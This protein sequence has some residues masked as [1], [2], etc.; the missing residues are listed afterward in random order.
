MP[1]NGSL[2]YFGKLQCVDEI[3]DNLRDLLHDVDSGTMKDGGQSHTREIMEMQLHIAI[4]KTQ[5]YQDSWRKRGYPGAIHNLFRKTDRLENINKGIELRGLDSINNN[6]DES[7]IDTLGDLA[8]YSILIMGLLM[9]KYPKLGA[10]YVQ[11]NLDFAL[12][13]KE[14]GKE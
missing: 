8:N 4:M 13:F 14:D 10:R 11:S 3:V 9:D 5:R 1:N 7:I 2:D 12:G 6:E